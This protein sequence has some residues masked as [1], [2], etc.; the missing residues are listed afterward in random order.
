MPW[1][2]VA[3]GV[4][5]LG[6]LIG[7]R[8][9]AKEQ[10][11]AIAAQNAY[12]APSAIRQRAE[13]AGFNPLLFVGPGVGQQTAVA[14]PVMGQAIA[15]AALSIA[16]GINDTAKQR[17]YQTALQQQNE[18]LRKALETAT[19]R[20]KMAG[21]YG[22][23]GQLNVSVP[24]APARSGLTFGDDLAVQPTP[25]YA[26]YI[27]RNGEVLQFRE[28][29]DFEDALSAVPM[30]AIAN[31]QKEGTI[32]PGYVDRFF[33][34]AEGAAT[35]VARPVFQAGKRWAQPIARYVVQAPVR[36]LR[37]KTLQMDLN[38]RFDGGAG[39]VRY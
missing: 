25:I 38:R 13:E 22:T 12:N 8:K 34:N 9:A 16:G 18:Q 20:P 32:D 7:G 11:R 19:V 33:K 17:A 10:A 30:E 37:Q 24:D 3:A 26:P 36:R 21:V 29:T 1:A 28:G 14:Q 27:G 4:S 35:A 2:A 6:S 39:D 31:L 15:D 23:G 5:A